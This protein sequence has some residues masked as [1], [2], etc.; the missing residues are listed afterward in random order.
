[1]LSRF[2]NLDN[3]RIISKNEFNMYPRASE[4]ESWEA[5]SDGL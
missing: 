2:F 4:R 1:M 3:I 5:L